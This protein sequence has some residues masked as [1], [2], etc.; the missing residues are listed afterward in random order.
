M[1]TSKFEYNIEKDNKLFLPMI[2]D[3]TEYLLRRSS[4]GR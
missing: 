3:D 1:S 4:S 2:D